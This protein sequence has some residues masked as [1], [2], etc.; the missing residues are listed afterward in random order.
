VWYGGFTS[1]QAVR[2]TK[3]SAKRLALRQEDAQFKSVF[4][5]RPGAG[6]GKL[7]DLRG[8]TF[9]LGSVSSTSGHL[10][11]RYFLLQAKVN[12]DRDMKQVGFSG[13]H[14]ATALWVESGR[15][16]AGALNFLVW[17][18][19]VKEKKVDT[20]KVNVFYLHDAA[21]R[22]LRLD[23]PRRPGCRSAGEDHVGVPQAGLR[24]P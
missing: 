7:E 12:P 24:Q 11:P 9:A 13:A 10:M 19:L 18:K 20:G 16:D 23:G 8:K 14:D 22:R 4:V 3:G 6:I 15:V 2:R 5:S 21:V 17:D 1:V